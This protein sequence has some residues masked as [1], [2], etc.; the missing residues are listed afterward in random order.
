M[1]QQRVY[2]RFIPQGCVFW[3]KA[4]RIHT[5]LPI[6]VS[7]TESFLPLSS[8]SLR[9]SAA[10]A[11]QQTNPS[12]HDWASSHSAAFFFHVQPSCLPLWYQILFF[13]WV[14]TLYLTC[15]MAQMDGSRHACV[16]MPT[17]HY[18]HGLH[19]PTQPHPGD[20]VIQHTHTRTHEPSGVHV[21]VL[22]RAAVL[23]LEGG[24]QWKKLSDLV[25]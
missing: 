3:S 22:L 10:L 1:R 18:L 25:R 2:C 4:C 21:H 11:D 7:F 19:L 8:A 17:A 23:W 20:W 13:L 16:P 12:P 5:A 6:C 9:L 15:R 24:M 14:N